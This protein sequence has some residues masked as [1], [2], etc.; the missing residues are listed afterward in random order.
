MGLMPDAD[1]L[2]A[3]LQ[4]SLERSPSQQE[5]WVTCKNVEIHALNREAASYDAM[6]RDPDEA[7]RAVPL[8]AIADA[9]MGFVPRE[10]PESVYSE[11]LLKF[12][13]C[14]K[15]DREAFIKVFKDATRALEQLHQLETLRLAKT[16]ESW[17][18]SDL[19]SDNE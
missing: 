4:S 10:D 3:E 2:R 15:D 9:A 1:A 18:D 19:E 13:E 6:M 7:S 5:A 12:L 16:S 17:A 8:S 14:S 11:S